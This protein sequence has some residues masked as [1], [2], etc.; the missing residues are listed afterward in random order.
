MVTNKNILKTMYLDLLKYVYKFSSYPL[1]DWK[2]KGLL[3]KELNRYTRMRRT[4]NV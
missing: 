4:F 1:A 3:S 2:A